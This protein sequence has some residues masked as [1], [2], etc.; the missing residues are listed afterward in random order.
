M[1]E[2]RVFMFPLFLIVILFA[3]AFDAVAQNTR[4]SSTLPY[5]DTSLPTD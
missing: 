3:V 4:S 5:L 1:R 2:C